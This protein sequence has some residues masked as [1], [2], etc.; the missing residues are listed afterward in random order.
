MSNVNKCKGSKRA[1]LSVSDKEVIFIP[2]DVFVIFVPE[3][4]HMFTLTTGYHSWL[5]LSTNLDFPTPLSP[6]INSFR[7][8]RTSSS[9]FLREKA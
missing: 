5:K 2:V 3:V 9:I 4:E 7:V 6:I 8:V 1:S